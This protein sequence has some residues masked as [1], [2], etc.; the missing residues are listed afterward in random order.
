M[1]HA[2]SFLPSCCLLN[3]DHKKCMHVSSHLRVKGIGICAEPGE[4]NDKTEEPVKITV[5][6]N[7]LEGLS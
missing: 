3:L 7:D 6:M 4:W 5:I 2:I 1:G